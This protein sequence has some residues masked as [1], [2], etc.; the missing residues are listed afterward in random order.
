MLEFGPNLPMHYIIGDAS[1]GQGR[2]YG[3]LGPRLE[4]AR[5]RIACDG[6]TQKRTFVMTRWTAHDC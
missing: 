4:R 2:G 3:S 5:V 6:A 1:Q